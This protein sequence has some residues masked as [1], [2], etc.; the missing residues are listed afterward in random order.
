MY[1]QTLPVPEDF[2]LSLRVR[3]AESTLALGREVAGLLRGGE[4][5]LLYGP[6]GAGK[7]CFS[8][9]L[10]RALGVTDE[11][12]SP[13]FTLVNTYT[14]GGFLVHHLDFYRVEP[15]HNLDDIGVPDILDEVF[16]GRALTLIEWPEPILDDLGADEPRLELLTLPGD[17]P[18]ERVWHLRGVPDI[19]APW[20][21][22]F[23]QFPASVE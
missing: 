1:D 22:L 23:E 7:T 21:R 10:C 19:P 11:V 3:G 18:D 9:G 15:D 16:S 17:D 12:V 20:V 13:T 5:I 14:G 2:T 8:Q 6:L 4:I